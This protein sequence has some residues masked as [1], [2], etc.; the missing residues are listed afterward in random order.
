MISSTSQQAKARCSLSR[1]TLFIIFLLDFFFSSCLMVATST[2]SNEKP[3]GITHIKV[4]IPILLD[5]YEMQRALI[6]IALTWR[7]RTPQ[8]QLFSHPNRQEAIERT[9]WSSQEVDLQNHTILNPCNYSFKLV[10]FGSHPRFCFRTTKPA[11]YSLRTNCKK[12]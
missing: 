12:C 3:F 4:Y 9:Q 8:Q 6:H 5:N 7:L 10:V 11:Q 1:I 2:T